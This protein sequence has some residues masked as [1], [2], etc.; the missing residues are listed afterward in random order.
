M[1]GQQVQVALPAELI[2]E[3]DGIM[4][5]QRRNEFVAELI[6]TALHHHKIMRSLAEQGPVWKDENHPE[7]VELG[8]EGWV[9]SLRNETEE[10]FLQLHR[11]E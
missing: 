4:G 3:V 9:R 11:D 8:T 5:E 6:R 10:R 7:L 1:E 2:R